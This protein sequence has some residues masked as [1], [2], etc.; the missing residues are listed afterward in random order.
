MSLFELVTPEYYYKKYKY[1]PT[2]VDRSLLEQY[3]NDVKSGAYSNVIK[4][5][6]ILYSEEIYEGIFPHEEYKFHYFISKSGYG[7]KIMGL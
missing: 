3:K 2:N 7:K 5:H 6:G 4:D 1:R